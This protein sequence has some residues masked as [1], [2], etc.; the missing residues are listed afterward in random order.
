MLQKYD[1]YFHKNSCVKIEI[2]KTLFFLLD[3]MQ[4]FTSGPKKPTN[5]SLNGLQNRFTLQKAKVN[6]YLIFHVS[7]RHTYKID[8]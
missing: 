7:K 8:L 3:I 4:I 6:V 5:I 1:V 2:I